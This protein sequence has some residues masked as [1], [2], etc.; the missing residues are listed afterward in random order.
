MGETQKR[1]E[2]LMN[3]WKELSLV[4]YRD[5][6]QWDVTTHSPERSKLKCL[7]TAKG[8]P[9]GSDGKESACSAGDMGD[10]VRSLGLEDP[11]EEE[12]ATYSIFPAGKIPWAKK[13]GK[14][15]S[16]GLKRVPTRLS[17]WT[18]SHIDSFWQM[19][20]LNPAA[21][22]LAPMFLTRSLRPLY[23]HGKSLQ[24]FLAGVLLG[25]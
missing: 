7:R 19:A 12:M 17:D 16:I 11:L 23:L 8:F 24:P 5:S 14:L 2:Q 3:I 10:V 22:I 15:Q 21:L 13:P 4:S 9:G 18:H 25:L 20:D 6:W 1:S